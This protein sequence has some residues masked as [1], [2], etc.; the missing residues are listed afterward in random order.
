MNTARAFAPYLV[1]LM[2]IFTLVAQPVPALSQAGQGAGPAALLLPQEQTI[3]DIVRHI[4]PAV[5]AVTT[6][7][8]N[9][10]EDGV[11]SG[12]IVTKDGNILTNNHVIT[13]SSKIVVTLADGRDLVARSLGGDPTIDLAILKIEG[14]NL[15]VAPLGDSDNL[16]VG[17]IAIAIGNPYGFERTVTVGVISALRRT[18]SD[19]DESLTNLIQTDAR[20]FPGNSGGP[21]LDSK[22]KVIGINT[23]VVG[24]R[25]GTVGFAIPISTAQ[26]I[27]RQVQTRGRVVLPWIGISYGELNADIAKEFGLKVQEGII[28]ANVEKDGPAALAGIR[29]GD[30]IIAVDNTKIKGSG[31]LRKA[32]RARN[33]G[34]KANVVAIRDG[35]ERNFV[36][37]IR[38]MP[39]SVQ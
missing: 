29:R 33:V 9:G 3:I 14:T 20:I 23:A 19:G 25:A 36:V 22:G 31:D 32:I 1:G 18:V 2:M 37:T 28:V 27:M 7:D 6:Y 13:G 15:P 5:V 21:L 10:D 4:S 8:K 11:G 12:V 16:Q 17:Q 35:Q 38:E 34:D 30:I 26:D 24:G 39:P